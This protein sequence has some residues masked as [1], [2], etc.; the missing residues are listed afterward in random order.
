MKRDMGSSSRD[1]LNILFRRAYLLVFLVVGLPLAVLATC[2]YVMPIYE[3]SGK[4]IITGKRENAT[5]LQGPAESGTSQYVNLNVDETDINSEMELL[6]S[7]DLWVRTVQKLGVDRFLQKKDGMLD[8][9]MQRVDR[10]WDGMAPDPP[11]LAATS[12]SSEYPPEVRNIAE[13]LVQKFKVV[14][15]PKSKVLDLTFKWSDPVLTQQVLSTLLELYIPYHVEVYS[16]PGAEKFFSGRGS[17]YWEQLQTAD[18]AVAEFKKKWNISAPEKQKGELITLIKQIQDSLV[19]LRSSASQY[20]QM[21]TSL[22]QGIVPTGQLAPSATRTGENTVINVIGTQLLRAQAKQQQTA[23]FFVPGTRD[24][25]MA[26]DTVKDLMN[27]LQDS[28]QVELSLIQTRSES[29]EESLK[30]KQVQLQQLEAKSEE[31]RTLQIAATIAKERYLQYMAKEEDA[32]MES[33]KSSD[34]LV[35]VRILEKPSTPK[36]PVF[37]KTA[38]FVLGGFL[39]AWPLGLGL[40]LL[41]NFFDHTFTNPSEVESATGYPVLISLKR[42]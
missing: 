31:A 12:A 33:L 13:A 38:L 34:K 26:E 21:L 41:A 5:L 1:V 18:A 4:V 6:L 40:I 19:D 8:G 27:K 22:K 9:W 32:R 11:V 15:T 36:T 30:T 24:T 37:P 29:M 25:R 42:L 14:P 28:L 39:I 16:L 7:L 3:S 17:Q 35:N 10:F 23:E 2:L 20:E